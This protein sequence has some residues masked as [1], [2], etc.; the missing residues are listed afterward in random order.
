MFYVKNIQYANK[1]IQ[2][3]FCFDVIL[4]RIFE[5][6]RYSSSCCRE[7]TTFWWKFMSALSLRLI[8]E[9]L[10]LNRG[11][12]QRFVIHRYIHWP[13]M[14]IVSHDSSGASLWG[15][16]DFYFQC[17]FLGGFLRR[18]CRAC[19][20]SHVCPWIWEFLCYIN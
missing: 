11:H 4:P 14:R 10:A 19:D 7:S 1:I 15:K 9:V 17:I 18:A 16:E 5:V 6:L 13:D 2:E 8:Y 12:S 3:L 20:Y